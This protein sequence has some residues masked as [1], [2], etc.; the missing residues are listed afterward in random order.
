M[1]QY[2]KGN[3]HMEITSNLAPKS[4]LYKVLNAKMS[5]NVSTQEVPKK[6]SKE[7]LFQDR[8]IFVECLRHCY[9]C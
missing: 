1:E 9:E 5:L 3:S 6:I 4:K 8:M 2:A 7:A